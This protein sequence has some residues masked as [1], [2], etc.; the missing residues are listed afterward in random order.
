MAATDRA[1][2]N[3]SEPNWKNRL[4]AYIEAGDGWEVLRQY[5][6]KGWA[7][8]AAFVARLLAEKEN[9]E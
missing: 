3:K 4:R 5:I 6:A 2:T 9:D 7:D 8:R 1:T